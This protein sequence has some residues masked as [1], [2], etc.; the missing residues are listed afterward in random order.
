MSVMPEGEPMSASAPIQP[1]R[2]SLAV[3]PLIHPLDD[4]YTQAGLALPLVEIALPETL[5]EAERKLLVHE[6]DMT[7]ALMQFYGSGLHLEVLRCETRGESY[8]RE[9]VLHLNDS[10]EAV[11][12]GAIKIQLDLLPS[13]ARRAILEGRVPLGQILKD[14]K[15]SYTSRP[16]AFLKVVPDA[17]IRKALRMLGSPVVWGRRNT[18]S[19][20]DRGP[21]AEIVEILPPVAPQGSGTRPS[22]ETPRMS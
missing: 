3:L 10:N 5:P 7:S 2:G 4:F 12:F 18:L 17:F 1:P 13:C 8:L 22:S 11:E 14:F 15:V 16:K 20:P 19:L 21:F 6:G 9:V